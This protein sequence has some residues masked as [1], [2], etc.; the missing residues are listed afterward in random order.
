[1]NSIMEFLIAQTKRFAERTYLID[2]ETDEVISFKEFN[3]R[4]SKTANLLY[5]LGIRKNEKVSLVMENSPEYLY[6]FFACLIHGAVACPISPKLAGE[7]VRYLLEY[8]GSVMVFYDD[9]QEKKVKG[10][11]RLQSMSK[12]KQEYFKE[13]RVYNKKWELGRDDECIMVFTS[14]T[15]GK[16]K[17]I[18]LTHGN[19]LAHN[20][21]LFSGMGGKMNDRHLCVLPITHVAGLF[22]NVINAFCCGSLVVLK[23]GFSRSS[24]WSDIENYKITFVQVVP[25]I[26]TML[27]NPKEDIRKKDISSLRFIGCASAYLPVELIRQF[28]AAFPTYIVELYGLSETTC[29]SIINPIGKDKR[30]IGSIGKPMLVNEATILDENQN[31]LPAYSAGE[32]AIHGKNI[33]KG[34]YKLP[35]ANKEVFKNSWFLTG[36]LGYKDKDGFFYINGRKKEVIIKGAEKISPKEID[37]V[38]FRNENVKEAATIGVPDKIYGEEIVSFI[39]QVERGRASEDE[40]KEF[41][42]LHLAQFKCPKFIVF[43]DDIPKGPSGKPLRRELLEQWHK[44]YIESCNNK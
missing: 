1:M 10:F 21:S 16:P 27:L 35:E 33:M 31:E 3:A 42:K 25:T 37:D 19:F 5:R 17:G 2:G 32:I 12:F 7:E 44:I 15:T 43:I 4:V 9:T 23:K 34:Y 6:L 13:S 36:D 28:E 40:L 38:L 24:F 26:L 39:V 20:A 14:G 30:K 41:C 22:M 29:K 8:T 18:V 11:A